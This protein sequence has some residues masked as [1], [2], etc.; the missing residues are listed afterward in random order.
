MRMST[1]IT[2]LVVG[3]SG[4]A[5]FILAYGYLGQQN[6]PN[7]GKVPVLSATQPLKRGD[8][9]ELGKNVEF[10][11]VYETDLPEDAHIDD[12]KLQADLQAKRVVALQPIGRN[13]LLKKST[14]GTNMNGLIEARLKDKPGFRAISISASTDRS[15]AGFIKPGSYVDLLWSGMPHGRKGEMTMVLMSN[16]EVAAVDLENS[17]APQAQGQGKEV[18]YLTFIVSQDDA[19]RLTFATKS[20]GIVTA[21]LR[22]NGADIAGTKP[23]K[24][25]DWNTFLNQKKAGEGSN[26][27]T[28]SDEERKSLESEG[29]A[30]V[31][32]IQNALNTAN[33]AAS[34]PV[35]PSPIAVVSVKQTKNPWFMF[36]VKNVDG[37]TLTR[38][39]VQGTSEFA[40]KNK[41]LLRAPEPDELEAINNMV[42]T[43]AAAG[44]GN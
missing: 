10:K 44:E 31:D 43:Q 39:P 28:V 4:L 26:E 30:L 15:V 37:K 11:M 9:L 16:V 20:G 1:L 5:A 25:I 12:Q 27:G 38:V 14:A 18:R 32:M 34:A 23:S 29:A 7:K 42:A 21:T 41:N 2:L 33:A 35:K 17:V 22:G 3:G 19:Q 40:K 13:D 8:A 36:E 24:E 6:D